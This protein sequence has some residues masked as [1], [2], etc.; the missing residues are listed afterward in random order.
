MNFLTEPEKAYLA[1]IIDGEGCIRLARRKR[2]SINSYNA[3]IIVTNCNLE[4]LQSLKQL[5]GL[6]IIYKREKLHN[7]NWNPCYRWQI[8]T[9][10]ARELL[11]IVLPYLRLKKEHARLILSSPIISQGWKRWKMKNYPID[12]IILK[13]AEI[14]E[15]IKKL[16]Q[17]G[18]QSV[19]EKE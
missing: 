11:E 1:G 17:R 7:P 5:T 15:Q 10:Q 19:S 14:F 2:K 9:K 16:N 3:C 12:A 4:L 8:L 18:M 6:G 13:Q